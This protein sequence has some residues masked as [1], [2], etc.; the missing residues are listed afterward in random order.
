MKRAKLMVAIVAFL[1]I[2]LTVL[3]LNT[4]AAYNH[5]GDTDSVNFR[6]AYPEKVGTKLDS[7]TTCHTGGSYISGGKTVTLGSCQWCHYKFGYNA[8]GD[9]LATLNQYGKD[10]LNGG[11]NATALASIKELDSDGDGYSNQVEIAAIR[12]PGD[13]NDTPA[14]VAA[15]SQ[16]FTRQE[17]EQ[18]PQHTQFLLMNAS[19]STDDYVQ[20]TGVTIESILQDMMLS[21]ATG[22]TVFSPDGFSTN[23]P[24]NPSPNPS[25][26]HVLG[27]YPA[28]NFNYSEEAD[29][30]KNP[31][32][33]ANYSAPSCSNRV[34]A[35]PSSTSTD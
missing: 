9:I 4:L 5:Q 35:T 25:S 27:T 21:S 18:M 33:W 14:K 1:L 15:P 13:P 20:Y 6:I 12:F 16:V 30:A 32:G 34:N 10:Y 8:S 3:P 19:K 2:G 17:L 11:R 22:I 23:H 29:I 26:Y 7:C 28:A 31:A 24:L